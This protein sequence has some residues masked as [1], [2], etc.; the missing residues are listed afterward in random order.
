MLPRGPS[1]TLPLSTYQRR[2]ALG[3]CLVL[4]IALLITALAQQI[5][6]AAL[7]RLGLAQPY[8]WA[9][10][11]SLQ[12]ISMVSSDDGWAVGDISG[13]PNTLLMHYSHG[14]WTV[15]PKPAGLDD[16]SEFSAVSMVSSHDGWAWASK[17]D[18]T[19]RPLSQ[20]PAGWRAAA[21]RR[22]SV[23][24]RDSRLPYRHRG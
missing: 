10:A 23:E 12:S 6:Q 7:Y 8:P 19:W 13:S 3:I 20:L 15:L 17:D 21:L 9:N 18:P 4:A 11:M 14:Q 5:P 22:P 24:D 1:Y 2:V 16:S